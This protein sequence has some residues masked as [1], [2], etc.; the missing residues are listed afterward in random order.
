MATKVLDP[1]AVAVYCSS[2][3]QIPAE[4]F[5]GGRK[6]AELLAQAG[7]AMVYGG[8]TCGLMGAIS[9]AHKKAGGHLVG[10]VPQFMIDQGI[11]SP[12]LDD[13]VVVPDM[14][15]RKDAMNRRAGGFVVLP[16]GI[17]TFDEFFDILALKQLGIHQKPIVLLNILEYFH[18]LVETLKHAVNTG[19]VKKEYLNLFAVADAPQS[20]MSFLGASEQ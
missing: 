16:G 17:G 19:T 7:L 11:N 4:F 8:T 1:K 12:I 20:V 9:E 14:A 3:T 10:V 18:P 2:S 15:A 6:L 13:L 5:A